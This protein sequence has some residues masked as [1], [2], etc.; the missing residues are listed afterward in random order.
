MGS[1]KQIGPTV[2]PNSQTMRDDVRVNVTGRITAIVVHPNDPKTIYVG[3]AQGGIWKTIDE[4]K[5][6]TPTS[7]NADSLAIGALAMDPNNPEILYAGTGEGNIEHLNSIYGLG[8]LKTTNGGQ[9]WEL[10]AKRTFSKDRFFRIAVNPRNSNYIFAATKTGLYRSIDAG[11][12]W[13]NQL[14]PAATDIVINPL[15]PNIAYAAIPARGIYKTSNASDATPYWDQLPNFPRY[16]FGRIGLGISPSSPQR[17]YA[18]MSNKNSGDLDEFYHTGD[19]GGSWT[20][21]KLPGEYGIS[22]NGTY[23]LEVAVNPKNPDIVYLLATSIWKAV[24]DAS[25]SKWTITDVGSTIHADQHALAFNTWNN[26][27]I[28][29]GNDG[30]IYRSTDG[31]N[32][33]DDSINKGL[34]ITQFEFMEQDPKDEK[35]IIAGTQDNGTVIYEGK[36]EFYHSADGDGGFVCIDPNNSQN[37]WHTFYGLRPEIST[38]GGKFQTWRPL[39]LGRLSGDTNFYPPM[40]LDKTNANNIAIGGFFLYIDYSKGNGG[41]P[42]RIDLNQPKDKDIYGRIISD[43]ISANNFFKEGL[44]QRL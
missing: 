13:S 23:N 34:C 4:G 30:G 1:W 39:G 40:T 38:E 8:I 32:N 18:L 16:G 9:T 20:P 6:W 5:H 3:A 22:P 33:W 37:V 43:I 44:L 10:K 27:I 7:D 15:D 26:N 36:P 11:E 21:I 19:G 42:D 2:V 35:R 28:Y 17:L 29:V 14:S 31:G 25:S 41:W 12:S 24:R